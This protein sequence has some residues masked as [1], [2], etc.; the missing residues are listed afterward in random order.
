MAAMHCE[1]VIGSR[2]VNQ[3]SYFDA[4][5]RCERVC[6]MQQL[7]SKLLRWSCAF[8]SSSSEQKLTLWPT[9]YSKR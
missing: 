5:T 9:R 8:F 6:A 7:T 4:S 2:M 1:C 3:S